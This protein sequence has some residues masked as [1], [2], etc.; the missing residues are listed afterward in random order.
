MMS[1]NDN[2][3]IYGIWIP[4][5]GWLRDAEGKVFGDQN[6]VKCSEVATLIGHGSKV[7]FIDD[8]IVNLEPQYLEQEKKSKWHIF[9]TF[10][11]HKL[12]LSDNNK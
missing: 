4:D 6:I 7:R 12:K 2:V 10:L 3:N 5:K 8:A 1:N 9:K 11:R